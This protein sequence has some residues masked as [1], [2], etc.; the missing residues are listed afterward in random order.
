MNMLDDAEE[1]KRMVKEMIEMMLEGQTYGDRRG[2]AFG[3]AG[4]VKG[5]GISALKAHDI[6]PTLQVS[7]RWE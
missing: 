6:M 4:M 5:I 3:L 2:A 7:R 1:V